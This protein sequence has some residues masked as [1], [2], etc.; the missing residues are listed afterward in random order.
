MPDFLLGLIFGGVL[1][2]MLAG[3]IVANRLRDEAETD[4]IIARNAERQWTLHRA[5]YRKYGIALDD[6]EFELTERSLS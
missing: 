3:I 4:R 5:D 1:G 6:I 2:G